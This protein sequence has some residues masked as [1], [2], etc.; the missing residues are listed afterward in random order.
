[1]N[2]FDG[3]E[4]NDCSPDYPLG[5]MIEPYD[6]ARDE[7]VLINLSGGL[8]KRTLKRFHQKERMGSRAAT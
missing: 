4:I 7:E 1:M 8:L 6:I 3:N 2:N 5:G